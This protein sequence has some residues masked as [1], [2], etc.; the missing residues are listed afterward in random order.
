[1]QLRLMYVII[2]VLMALVAALTGSVVTVVEGGRLTAAFKTA[3][4][5]FAGSL[6]LLI[7]VMG[8]LGVVSS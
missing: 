1:M 8:A 3:A 6:S 5:T 4:L 7:V 2:A